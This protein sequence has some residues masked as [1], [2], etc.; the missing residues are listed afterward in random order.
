MHKQLAELP[1]D[2]QTEIEEA[3]RSLRKS[4]AAD[5]HTLLPLSVINRDQGA[6]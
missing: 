6:S 1:T 3:G 2:Q 5:G 4:R